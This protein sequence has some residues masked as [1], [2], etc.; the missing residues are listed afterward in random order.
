MQQL[1]PSGP[2]PAPVVTAATHVPAIHGYESKTHD[3]NQQLDHLRALLS[4]STGQQRAV[5]LALIAVL[6]RIL[7]RNQDQIIAS[8]ALH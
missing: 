6:T 5:I 7:D 8:A 2:I 3:L 4:R 1:H